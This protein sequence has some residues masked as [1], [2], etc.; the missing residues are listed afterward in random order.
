MATP[1]PVRPVIFRTFFAS[2]VLIAAIAVLG[3][4][5]FGHEES[6][7]LLAADSTTTKSPPQQLFTGWPVDQ[8]PE[9]VLLVTGQTYGY[10]QKCGCSNPQKGGLERRY[11][12][13]EMMRSKGWEVVGLDLGDVMRP[14]PYTPTDKQSLTKYEYA[15]QAMKAMG[16]K[17]VAVGKEELSAQ[18]INPLQRFTLQKGNEFPKVLFAN[19]EN[20]LDF[21]DATGQGSALTASTIIGAPKSDLKVGVTGI[22]GAEIQNQGGF[23]NSVQLSP[24]TGPVLA[25][26]LKGWGA[27]KTPPEL[28]VLLYQGPLE[29][30]DPGTNQRNDAETIAGQN[31]QFHI[32]VCQTNDSEPPSNPKSVNGGRTIIVQ[33]GQRGQNV[34]VIGIFRIKGTLQ[35]FYQRVVMSDEFDT[36]ADKTDEQPVLKLLQE[37]SNTVKDNDFLSEMANRKKFHPSQVQ[38]KEAAFVGDGQ[39]FACHKEEHGVWMKSKHASAHSALETIATRPSGRQFDGECIICHTVGYDYKTGFVNKKTTPHLMNVQCESCHGP[40]SLHVKEEQEN[41]KAAKPANKHLLM[42]SPWKAGNPDVKL[43]SVEKFEAMSKSKDPSTRDSIMNT[44]EKQ[45]YQ[46]VYNTC[47]KCHDMDNDPKFELFNYWKNIVHTGLSPKKP[48]RNG[49]AKK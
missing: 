19:I 12:F 24:R 28:N 32:V 40:G 10:L 34:G 43:P 7:Q 2:F 41:L 46:G 39:C 27:E 23:D 16:Y 15:M 25:K 11:N 21:P 17:A 3:W 47:S 37:Y 30:K 45:A 33:V 42:M 29:W 44:S 35:L 36:P 9:M 1:T 8:K 4:T 14:L 38:F 5:L 26:V 22:V 18:L 49:A 48:A 20:P 6:A 13:V 31:P